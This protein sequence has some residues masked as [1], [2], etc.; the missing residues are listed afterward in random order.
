MAIDS[1][2]PT[3][4]GTFSDGTYRFSISIERSGADVIVSASILG[5]GET[6]FT[7]AFGPIAVS[8]PNLKTLDFNR[9]GLWA[10]SPLNADQMSFSG[11]DL[12]VA[13]PPVPGDFNRD[14]LVDGVDFK[15]WQDN[16]SLDSNATLAQGDAD[17]DGDVDGADF[18]VWQT[19]FP[20]AS[21]AS[22]GPVPEPTTLA[23]VLGCVAG[24][25]PFSRRLR[26]HRVASTNG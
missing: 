11:L 13:D 12:T 15:A 19:N 26:M 1:E 14:G 2:P 20:Y 10:V 16:F 4:N 8:S 5:S 17:G 6:V 7:N 18:V 24:L 21:G 22:V 3:G 23:L 25:T 9:A